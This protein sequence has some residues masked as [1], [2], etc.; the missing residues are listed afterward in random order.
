MSYQKHS[1]HS[2]LA[3]C[4]TDIKKTMLACNINDFLSFLYSRLPNGDFLLSPLGIHTPSRHLSHHTVARSYILAMSKHLSRPAPP[5]P[6]LAV[7]RELLAQ[8]GLMGGDTQTVLR[9]AGLAHAAGW[10]LAPQADGTLSREAAAR[11][12]AECTWALDAQAAHQEGRAPLTKGELDLLCHCI[13]TCR[14]LDEAISRTTAFSDMLVPRTA[15]LDL[16]VENGVATLLMPTVRRIRNVSAFVSDL[17]GLLMHHRLFGWLIGEDIPLLE[18]HLP[19]PP[20]LSPACAAGLM[21]TPLTYRARENALR[22][23]APLLRKPVV[24]SPEDLARLLRHFPFDLHEPQSLHTPLSAQ[25]RAILET[26]LAR[27]AALPSGQEL[28]RQF[29]ISPATLKRRLAEEGTTFGALKAEARLTL[30]RQLLR[31]KT[32][33]AKEI[34]TRLGFSDA[35]SFRRAF[36]H[37]TGQAPARWRAVLPS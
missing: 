12:F 2:P 4:L 15:H 23:P 3:R 24:R 10:L 37:W 1:M 36:R 17:V 31:D 33:P 14:T 28:A 11:L 8:V 25:L 7:T 34:A 21:P 32:L 9:R 6:S 22:F 13:I 29:S 27:Q 19:Y 30:A 5:P 26:A 20:L 35:A 18:V 16:T